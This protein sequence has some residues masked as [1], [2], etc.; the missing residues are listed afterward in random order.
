MALK[1]SSEYLNTCREGDADTILNQLQP[2]DTWQSTFRAADTLQRCMDDAEL[3]SQKGKVGGQSAGDL[4]K[5][6]GRSVKK[7]LLY[8]CIL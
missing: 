8:A 2:L 3:S 4:R 6:L 1:N 7:E 5:A